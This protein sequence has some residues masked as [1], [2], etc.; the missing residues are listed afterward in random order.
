MTQLYAKKASDGQ[1]KAL[2]CTDEGL[3][4]VDTEIT[5]TLDPTGLATQTT[6]AAVLAK[7]SA[8]PATQTTL[9]AILAKIIAAPASEAK[10]DSIIAKLPDQSGG[11]VPVTGPLTA[12]ERTAQDP[13]TATLQSAL[14]AKFGALSR[15][16]R[17]GQQTVSSAGTEVAL[18]STQVFREVVVIANS[19]N[20]GDIYVGNDGTDHVSSTT[21]AIL[22]PGGFMT[23]HEVDIADIY[24]DAEVSGEGVSF[25]GEI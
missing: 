22:P 20:T 15:T 5:A 2:E 6:L 3:L 16:P 21:G 25:G 9:A 4:K 17:S 23:F 14:N 19:D 1:P 24:V 8:D 10:Q 11:K 7:L 13:A 12:A 18:G